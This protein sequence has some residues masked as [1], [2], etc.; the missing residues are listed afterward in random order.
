ME[1]SRPR[2]AGEL[3]ALPRALLKDAVLMRSRVSYCIGTKEGDV[4]GRFTA[5]A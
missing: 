5:D 2:R 3:H 4:N 1:A